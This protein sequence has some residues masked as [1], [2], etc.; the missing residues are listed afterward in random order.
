[1]YLKKFLK[2]TAAIKGQ[3]ALEYLIL[4]AALSMLTLAAFS[5]STDSFISKIQQKLQGNGAMFQQGVNKIIA[6]D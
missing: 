4:F 6:N 2:I 3:A 1:M 5:S